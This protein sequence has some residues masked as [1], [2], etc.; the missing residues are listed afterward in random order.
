MPYLPQQGSTC[1]LNEYMAYLMHHWRMYKRKTIWQYLLQ[2]W[3]SAADDFAPQGT[4]VSARREV[5]LSQL[6]EG[7][8]L[9]FSR[10]RPG[11]LLS[12]LQHTGQ[13]LRQRIPPAHGVYGAKAETTHLFYDP[14]ILLLGN[15]P[16]GNYVYVYQKHA[17]E[18]W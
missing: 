5:C 13:P 8:L 3:F 10:Q 7:M 4:L 16:Q 2:Q 17:R 9:A 14:E 12:I 11:G 1:L 6:E 18:Y 15:T